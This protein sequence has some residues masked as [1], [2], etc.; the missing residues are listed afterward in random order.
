M[1]IK[2]DAL[3]L[4][5]ADYGESDRM[6]TLFTLQ[7]GKLSARGRFIVTRFENAR[8]D[9]AVDYGSHA[10]LALVPRRVTGQVHHCAGGFRIRGGKRRIDH[11]RHAKRDRDRV[12]A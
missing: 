5:T 3:V 11:I 8:L 9:R 12:A 7:R 6:L 4:R 10:F 2:V 1:E